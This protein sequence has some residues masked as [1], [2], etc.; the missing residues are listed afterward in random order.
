MNLHIFCWLKQALAQCE[1]LE[2]LMC[3]K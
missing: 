1:E 2:A 3:K